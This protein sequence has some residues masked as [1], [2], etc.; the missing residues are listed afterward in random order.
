MFA[1]IDHVCDRNGQRTRPELVEV[2]LHVSNRGSQ[3][4][5]VAI[6]KIVFLVEVEVLVRHI[7]TARDSGDAVK[8]GCFVVHSLVDAAKLCCNIPYAT[9]KGLS[10]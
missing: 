4:Q 6:T 1:R 2:V 3:Q 7:A 5:D 8:D 10:D 9:E